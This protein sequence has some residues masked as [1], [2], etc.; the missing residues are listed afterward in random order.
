[1]C[2][3]RDTKCTAVSCTNL[4]AS[5]QAALKLVIYHVSV[6]WTEVLAELKWLACMLLVH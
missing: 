3:S 1:M 2:D 6:W 4:S 5:Q